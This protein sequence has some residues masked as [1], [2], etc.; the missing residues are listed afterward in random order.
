MPSSPHNPGFD[1]SSYF[2]LD[3]SAAAKQMAALN[4]A[5]MARIANSRPPPSQPG[6]GTNSG[7]Y[8]GGITSINQ[9]VPPIGPSGSHD[10]T[11]PSSLTG[12]PNFQMPNNLNLQPPNL[13]SNHSY[14]D[15]A[16]SQPNSA[17]RNPAQANTSLKQ[18]QRNFLMGLANVMANRNTPLPPAL[19][20]I[21]Y[22]PNYD[23]TNSPWKIIEPSQTELG[24]FRLAGRDVDL[25][26][27]W[28]IVFQAGGGAKARLIQ[29]HPPVPHT[30]AHD[31]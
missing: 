6:G 10:A 27:L 3:P 20:G 24:S 16:M 2:N 19:T 14:V 25:F 18:R 4:A 9:P 1:P 29:H 8:L 26:R 12:H 28:G 15:P 21:P 11:N 31:F 17:P 13:A 22:P 7:P 5:S 30:D 23:P